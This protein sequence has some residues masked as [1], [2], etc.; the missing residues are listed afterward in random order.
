MLFRSNQNTGAARFEARRDDEALEKYQHT[1]EL[2]PNYPGVHFSLGTVYYFKG[3]CKEA[4]TEFAKGSRLDGY[5]QTADALEQGFS[6][7]GCRGAWQRELEAL[8]ELS[9]REYVEPTGF[10]RAYMRLGDKDRA[11]EWLEK[12]Y[13]EHVADMAKLKIGRIWDPL[14]SDPRFKDLLRRMNFPP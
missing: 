2:D 3:K 1:L 8:K 6:R 7:G 10:A 11:L 4:V 5:N 12:G 14:R 9:K 13:Q